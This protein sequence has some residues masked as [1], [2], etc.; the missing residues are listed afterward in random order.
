MP[1][2]N[3]GPPFGVSTR[4]G[5]AILGPGE[6]CDD[7]EDDRVDA[8]TN[9]CQTR[10]QLLEPE[11][12]QSRVLGVGRHPIAG[13][14]LGFVAVDA[15]RGADV[16]SVHARLFDIWGN[17]S[18]TVV[19]SD[20][21]SPS[22]ESNP[23]AAALPGGRYAIA[24]TDILG[25][26]VDL[27]IALRGVERDGQLGP[28]ISANDAAPFPQIEPDLIW[29]GSELIAAWVDYA[30][31]ATGPD[32]HYR[33]FDENLFPL[34]E[35]LV[36]ANADAAETDVSLSTFGGSWA[37]A[38]REYSGDRLETVVV[39]VGDTRYRVGPFPAAG[40]NDR[41]ALTALDSQHL[42]VVFS[43]G[44]DV[45]DE[46]APIARLRYAVLDTRVAIAPESVPLDPLDDLLSAETQISH[47]TP[48]AQT[49]DTD[50]YVAW[51]SSALSGDGGGDQ[52][53]LKVLRWNPE[54]ELLTTTSVENL[55]PRLCEE[56][57]GNQSSP[58]L[59]STLLPPRGALVATWEDSARNLAPNASS[60]NVVVEYAPRPS[61][62]GSANFLELLR[63]PAAYRKCTPNSPCKLDEGCCLSDEDCES[64]LACSF[65]Q[66]AS[67]GLSTHAGVCTLGASAQALQ[68]T[69]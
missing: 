1:A 48:A 65:P 57:F 16:P 26:G 17:A 4:C 25:D 21:A 13:G 56:S 68:R 51:S 40:R 31:V 38:Y 10:D 50:T 46:G 42:L 64:S 34:S 55:M 66:G 35:E 61:D 5:D 19:I 58:A 18:D 2:Q 29:T 43:T 23:V 53:W 15:A 52:L 14:E 8:C 41:P 47:S 28:L 22:S 27:G 49:I 3:G 59:A 9:D 39:S 12:S 7:G 36:L 63:Q 20:G 33:R 45:V 6:E 30:D 11:A 32:I 62:P 44:R 37:A 24:W 67:P 69:N 54:T 60:P